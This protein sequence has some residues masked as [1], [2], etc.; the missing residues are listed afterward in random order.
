MEKHKAQLGAAIRRRR[1]SMSPPMTL[2]QL[3]KATHIGA[4]RLGDIERGIWGGVRPSNRDEI[5]RALGWAPG[6]WDAVLS[7][8]QPTVRRNQPVERR[9]IDDR[10]DL[11]YVL[12]N[13]RDVSPETLRTV[14]IIIES[15]IQKSSQD[16][17]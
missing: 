9:R 1:E 6:S 14:R 2:A 11:V 12:S 4:R 13:A 5:E 8:G 15:E 10:Q 17:L 7:G 3:A 16:D